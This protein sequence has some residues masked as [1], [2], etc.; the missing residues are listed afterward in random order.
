M[1]NEIIKINDETSIELIPAQIKVNGLDKLE[2]FVANANKRATSLVVTEQ[3]FKGDKKYRTT[4]N[5]LGDRLKRIRIDSKNELLKPYSPFE[6]KMKELE[7]SVAN[8][9]SQINVQVAYFEEQQ[10]EAK[11]A[12][13]EDFIA[14]A[15]PNYNC[16]PQEVEI[17]DKWLNKSTSN[18][19][20]Q[21]A[22][23]ERMALIKENKEH[24]KADE[25]QLKMTADLLGVDATPYINYL[26]HDMSVI[27]IQKATKNDIERQKAQR[28]EREASEKVVHNRVVDKATGE[29][30]AKVQ[31]VT[32]KLTGTSDKLN[33]LRH[34]LDNNGI[35]FERVGD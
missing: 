19:A 32:L 20:W 17:D 11:K 25:E 29:V 30:K 34:Y 4:L 15:A 14:I 2:E 1:A 18:K 8:S 26:N 9:S 7:S 3:T 24:R 21:E 33:A 13:I 6:I 31:S 16:E 23:T 27:D 10:R 22:V 5:K 12:K 35:K 28:A